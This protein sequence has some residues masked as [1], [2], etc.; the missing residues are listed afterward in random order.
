[1]QTTHVAG[2]PPA[3]DAPVR[4]LIGVGAAVFV[5]MGLL[6]MSVLDDVVYGIGIGVIGLVAVLIALTSRRARG[7]LPWARW[8]VDRKDLVAVAAFYAAVVALFSLAFRVF[9]TDSTLGMFL[10]FGGG[11]LLGVLGPV[12]YTVWLRRRPLASLGVT[13]KGWRGVVA[14]ALLFASVQFAI[15]LWGYDLPRPVDWVPLLSMSLTVGLFESVFF[16]GFVQGRLEAGFG[17]AP[18]VAVA[19]VLY[20]LY[21]V[22]YG[23]GVEEMTFLFGLGIVYAVAFRIAN[24]LF[25]L[26][27]LL[28]PLGSFFAQL[29]SGD[30]TGEL[31]WAAILG[32]ADVIGLMV[33]AIWLA[34]R[35]ERNLDRPTDEVPPAHWFEDRAAALDR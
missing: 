14:L 12:I 33:A 20:S 15:T 27:P 25:V 26:W 10:S 8:Q 17:T 29:E 28:T 34:H 31:P 21:H 13:L 30:L 11:L 24:N 4:M 5:V 2:P 23:M 18:S 6:L 9:T 7:A 1:M 19:A 3:R 22:A 35:H 32:F 16:R